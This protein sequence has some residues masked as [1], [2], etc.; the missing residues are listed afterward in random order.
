MSIGPSSFLGGGLFIEVGLVGHFPYLQYNR[1][2]KWIRKDGITCEVF[3]LLSCLRLRVIGDIRFYLPLY[4]YKAS[5]M[6][7]TWIDFFQ[8]RDNTWRAVSGTGFNISV[9]HFIS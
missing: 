2:K 8:S 4:M 6:D 3:E 9:S 7:N 5:L 1:E